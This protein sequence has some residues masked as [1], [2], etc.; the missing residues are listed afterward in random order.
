M[1]PALELVRDQGIH[2]NAGAQP[3]KRRRHGNHQQQSSFGSAVF[4][5]AI[6]VVT[7]YRTKSDYILF[8]FHRPSQFCGQGLCTLLRSSDC[9]VVSL[10]LAA[11]MEQAQHSIWERKA[12]T[13]GIPG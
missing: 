9:L 7:L 10:T 12:I 4:S 3:T 13:S 8:P 6:P 11:G 1:R 2:H 5:R